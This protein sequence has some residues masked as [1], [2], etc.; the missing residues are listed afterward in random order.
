[1][2]MKTSMHR[3]AVRMMFCSLPALAGGLAQ[4]APPQIEDSEFAAFRERWQDAAESLGVPGW[5]LVAVRGDEVILLDA[6][7]VRSTQ[8]K[9]P[10]NADTM[11]YIASCTKP[12]NAM[13]A[14]ALAADGKLKLD[15]PVRQY[16]PQM[17]LK[18]ADLAAKLTVRDLLCHRWG[19]TS[20]DIVFNDAYTGLITDD[21]YFQL[22]PQ[23][24]VSGRVEYTNVH[25][26]LAGRVLAS[27][28]GKDW[29]DVLNDRI[30]A[31]A[32]MKRTTGY[33]SRMYADKNVALPHVYDG[34][35]KPSPVIKTDRTMHAAGGLG[36]TA[37]DLGRWLRL[38][39]NAGRI[40]GKQIIPAAAAGEML[41]YQSKLDSPD[42][43]IRVMKGFGLGWQLGDYRNEHAFAAHGGGYIGTAA[44]IAFLPKEKFG[45]AVLANGD[46]PGQGFT[47]I[48]M[49]D[50]FDHVLGYKV[51]DDLLPGYKKHAARWRDH[52]AQPP[53]GAVKLAQ[54][55]LTADASAYAGSYAHAVWGTM[56]LRLSGGELTGSIGDL[57]LTAYWT[58]KDACDLRAAPGMSYAGTFEVK[59]GRVVA[60]TLNNEGNARRFE[61]R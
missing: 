19:I 34:A 33:A 7:G 10:V 31:P 55:D 38:N 46:G 25:F 30:L 17:S 39:M 15:A 60:I 16:L 42:G 5:A 52:Q 22:L 18:D 44:Y 14:V 45:M 29:R 12:F 37:S 1:M 49:V 4:A 24:D 6:G 54:A 8:T 41:E 27:V 61:R 40:D 32:G 9:A 57:P 48:V 28:G 59:D 56:E 50:M 23:A 21:L 13:A 3:A 58:G 35:W 47:A 26:T 43:Q 11:F 36:T 53:A 20:G 2:T 51:E